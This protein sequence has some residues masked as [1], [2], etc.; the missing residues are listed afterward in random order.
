[1]EEKALIS[2]IVPVYNVEKY[3]RECVDS[4]CGQKGINA[5]IILVDD[6]SKDASGA[7]CDEY[8]GAYENIKVIH[9]ENGGLASARN[10]GLDKIA[11]KYVGFVDSDDYVEED[12]Y[13]ALLEALVR[14]QSK[15]ACCGWHRVTDDGGS[16]SIQED[17]GGCQ[18][19]KVY[20]SEEAIRSLLLNEG[21]TY[22][23]CD[24]LFAAELFQG[25][26]FPA[27]NLPS[28]DI[29]CIY[30]IL[31]EA[32]RVVHT[33]RKKYYYRVV[34]T[35]ISRKQFAPEN[36]STVV[37]MRE[38]YE[39]IRQNTAVLKE[40]ALFALAQS[41]GSVYARLIK[42]KKQKLC[43]KEKKQI[44]ALLKK[45]RQAIRRNA[46]LSRNAKIISFAIMYKGYP[47][48]AKLKREKA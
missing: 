40:E 10:A 23:A 39:D 26:R 28:E 15:V 47:L 21:M 32:G 14:T 18:E 13:A 24:K 11:G 22:S 8:A 37:Y 1:M 46:F 33:G 7:I 2:I 25:C 20:T 36:M 34:T 35:S 17:S 6:G 16:S 43:R 44:E 38:I 9:K 45:H 42:D 41:A 19:E 4:I 31:K 27:S 3:L 29:P 5:E 48:L 30:Q 12:M